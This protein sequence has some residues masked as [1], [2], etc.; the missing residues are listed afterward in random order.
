[1][2]AQLPDTVFFDLDG[3]IVQE[4][5]VVNAGYR[6]LLAAVKTGRTDLSQEEVDS[7]ALQAEVEAVRPVIRG[8][9]PL[10]KVRMLQDI[11]SPPGAGPSAGELVVAWYAYARRY[12]VRNY[13]PQTYLVPGAERLLRR[14]AP[15]FRIVAVTANPAPQAEWLLQYVGLRELFFEVLAYGSEVEGQGTKGQMLATYLVTHP[16]AK[17]AAV[18]GDGGPDMQAARANGLRGVGIYVTDLQQQG[19][20]DAGA[21]RVFRAGEE[22]EE[23]GDWLLR[24]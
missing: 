5:D 18:V 13:P 23:L 9:H 15:R 12:I 21:A 2:A 8:L 7:L 17:R 10:T 22:Y 6:F 11:L 4:L 14:L 24:E 20:V 19:L 3:V 1:M 16:A